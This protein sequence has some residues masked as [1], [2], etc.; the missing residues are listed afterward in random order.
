MDEPPKRRH[1]KPD[2]PI[3]IED[4]QKQ[5]EAESRN[6]LLQFDKGVEVIRAFVPADPERPFKLR[7]S[8]ILTLHRI[9]LDGL[10]AFAGNFRPGGVT[11]SG[12]SKHEPPPAHL[13]PELIEEFCD[14]VNEHWE[15]AT[16]IHLAAYAMWRLNWIHPFAD[17]NGRTSRIVSYIL[18]CI[19][20]GYLIPGTKTIPDQ[21]TDNRNPYFIALDEAD[22]A[23]KN[24]KK[25][26]VSAM[27]A[28]LS[29]LLAAQFLSAM[30][31]AGGNPREGLT[32]P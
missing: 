1:S 15:V 5:A 9:A 31:D 22:A 6:A 17:G 27:E 12:D 25:L 29:A 23:W 10:H 11:I 30:N 4:P 28:L 2:D 7:P 13:V 32:Q 21:I 18:L 20:L 26:D 14:Y 3:V 8:L 24:G 16:A 19:K